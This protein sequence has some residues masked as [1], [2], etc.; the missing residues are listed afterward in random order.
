MFKTFFNNDKIL[1]CD[2]Y[3]KNN[4][5]DN[6][7]ITIIIINNI[8]KKCRDKLLIFKLI[9][10]LYHYKKTKLCIG[11]VNP[12]LCFYDVENIESLLNCMCNLK[13][14]YDVEK[15]QITSNFSE[16]LISKIYLKKYVEKYDIDLVVIDKYNNI[17]ISK[18]VK[19]EC[20]NFISGNYNLLDNIKKFDFN[21][22]FNYEMNVEFVD[23]SENGVKNSNIC[24]EALYHIYGHCISNYFNNDIS[25]TKLLIELDW[26]INQIK[27]KEKH[28]NSK[29]L[30]LVNICS[31]IIHLCKLKNVQIDSYPESNFDN[32][33]SI[34]FDKYKQMIK[35]LKI[36]NVN[37]IKNKIEH[38]YN[39]II[40]VINIYPD[41]V[42]NS[43]WY[44]ET[45]HGGL[46]Y[47]LQQKGCICFPITTYLSGYNKS[48]IWLNDMII[49]KYFMNFE[50]ILSI[51]K[52]IKIVNYPINTI[53]LPLFINITH[54]KIAKHYIKLMLSIGITSEILYNDKM[55]NIYY[56]TLVNLFGEIKKN[57]DK[58]EKKILF[59]F[60]I[61][62]FRTCCQISFENRYHKGFDKYLENIQ[63]NSHN[64][65]IQPNILFGQM[66]SIGKNYTSIIKNIIEKKTNVKIDSSN[67]INSHTGV[68]YGLHI[69][70][71]LKVN[72]GGF[73][74]L[75]KIIDENNGILPIEINDYAF[76]KYEEKID[77]ISL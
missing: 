1:F 59:K 30:T 18:D 45:I 71:S 47:I 52:C 27:K 56:V 50:P 51:D 74:N 26:F 65:N 19:M 6:K 62:L 33:K 75:L 76:Q 53:F 70:E 44:S 35:Y 55:I 57:N 3:E 61:Q 12:E 73:K 14:I 31:E 41:D 36:I 60:C 54:W 46:K 77:S 21:D 13:F 66:L 11:Y 22:I 38:V 17:Q 34:P 37:N 25:K 48:G 7:Q 24:I 15:Y 9:F 8:L 39:E 16:D 40:D 58:Q 64:I 2:I 5:F 63:N 32:I 29:I 20:K 10:K 43:F 67:F 23:S 68:F 4:K 49:T 42:S 72:S 69:I 28:N